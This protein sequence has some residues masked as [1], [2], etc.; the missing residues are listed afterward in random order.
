MDEKNDISR[1]LTFVSRGSYVY[2]HS[3][4]YSLTGICIDLWTRTTRDLNISSTLDLLDGFGD[5]IE[6]FRT[7]KTDIMIMPI[8]EDQPASWNLTK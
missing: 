6:Y 2:R 7:N 3:A 4:D 5:V 8:D 1:A